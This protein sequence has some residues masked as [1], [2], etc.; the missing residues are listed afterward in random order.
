[1]AA[2]IL[3]NARPGV[4]ICPHQNKYLGQIHELMLNLLMRDLAIPQYTLASFGV[5]YALTTFLLLIALTQ[6]CHLEKSL[7]IPRTE[8]VLSCT[9]DFL[10]KTTPALSS[11][12]STEPKH[13][14]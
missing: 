9:I 11:C 1:M 14:L 6:T 7:A 4:L 12:I 3:I 8:L 5:V 2:L 10:L 13:T